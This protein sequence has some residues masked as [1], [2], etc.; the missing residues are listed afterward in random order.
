MLLQGD[1][2]GLLTDSKCGGEVVVRGI[3]LGGVRENTIV[4]GILTPSVTIGM[5]EHS[6]T[7]DICNQ[8]DICHHGLVRE[9]GARPRFKVA[10]KVHSKGLRTYDMTFEKVDPFHL[11][12]FPN[13]F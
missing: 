6:W 1:S 10:Y 4:P 5:D 3:I 8:F 2:G 9:L 7:Q 12:H 11:L 13:D